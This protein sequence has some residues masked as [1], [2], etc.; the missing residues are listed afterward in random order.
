[1][2]FQELEHQRP[3]RLLELTSP[4][5]DTAKEKIEQ[6]LS[7]PHQLKPLIRV[8]LQGKLARDFTGELQAAFKDRAILTFK[9]DLEDARP[10]PR[11]LEEHKLS[12]QELGR[13]L[14]HQNLA[15]ANLDPKTFEAVFEL[16]EEKNP[17]AAIGLL[18]ER[19]KD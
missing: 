14:L 9:K 15:Q 3:F 7:Q 11:G 17:D 13:K 16:L 5:R 6:L 10:Q 2:D 19:H 8:K 4:D 1:T 12:V 18:R